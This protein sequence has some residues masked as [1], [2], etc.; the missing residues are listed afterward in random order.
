M[1]KEVETTTVSTALT[2]HLTTGFAQA[3]LLIDEKIA[4]T[5]LKKAADV[6]MV[7]KAGES[8]G[9]DPIASLNS[10]DFI[11]GNVALKAKAVPG[12]LSRAGICVELVKDYEVVVIDKK[13]IPI[14]EKNKDGKKVPKMKDGVP[15][16]YKE[17]DG[18]YMMKEI[19]D[20]V[21]TLRFVRFYPNLGKDGYLN[22]QEISFYW[23]DAENA[24]WIGKQNWK[25]LPRY[26]MLARC[27]IRGARLWAGDVIAGMYDNL[28]TAEFT[29]T[30]HITTEDGEVTYINN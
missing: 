27:L 15:Q 12:L 29:N 23:S 10:I 9:L 26:M 13:R 24:K 20:R 22:K 17:E 1:A 14:M 7:I 4:P 28:E 19:T 3:Q 16:F 8:M 6:Y 25:N 5:S 30:K 2:T 21:T 18:S 11:Q